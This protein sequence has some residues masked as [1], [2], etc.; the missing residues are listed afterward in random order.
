MVQWERCRMQTP[1]Y[2]T[3]CWKFQT[4]GRALYPLCRKADCLSGNPQHSQAPLLF[5]HLGSGTLPCFGFCVPGMV[6][7]LHILSELSKPLPCFQW[8]LTTNLAS[9]VLE[10]VPGRN[11]ISI[12]ATY[13]HWWLCWVELWGLRMKIIINHY[14]LWSWKGS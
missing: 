4:L 11:F 9:V 12:V 3:W 2:S 8:N 5:T 6:S 7:A 14:R 13:D 10:I 1:L